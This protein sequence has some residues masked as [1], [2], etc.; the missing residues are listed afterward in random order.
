M[1]NT[2]SHWN[3]ATPP[4]VLIVLQDNKPAPVILQSGLA[5]KT[6]P[7]IAINPKNL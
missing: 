4:R 5:G 2:F 3:L 7:D 1:K 6:N